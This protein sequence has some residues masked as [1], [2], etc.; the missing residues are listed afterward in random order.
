V[1]AVLL[2]TGPIVGF[3]YAGDGH[4]AACEAAIEASAQRGLALCTTWEVVGEAYTLF[5]MR[6]S[7]ADSAEPAL[8][9]L[10]WAR[11]SA[12]EL[13]ATTEPDHHRA[14]ALLGIYG[15]LRLSYVDALLLAVAERHRVEELITVD[16]RH[17]RTVRVQHR[18]TLTV[19]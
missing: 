17:F 2:D 4:H 5:R 14:A 6:Y 16:G 13:L 7:P 8:E 19:V 9:V 12:V 15:Q 1:R 11:E 18:L 3:L 10:R